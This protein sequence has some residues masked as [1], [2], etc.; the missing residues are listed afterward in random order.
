[1]RQNKSMFLAGTT[2]TVCMF[3]AGTICTVYMCRDVIH[4]IDVKMMNL[5]LHRFSDNVKNNT[6]RNRIK[7]LFK[8]LK[9]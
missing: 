4:N 3:R 5:M 2:C 6:D 1:M 9:N 7:Q 8:I